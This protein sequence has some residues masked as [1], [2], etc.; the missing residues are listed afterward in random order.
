MVTS[1]PNRSSIAYGS[2][3]PYSSSPASAKFIGTTCPSS[4]YSSKRSP[5][6]ERI[7]LMQVAILRVSPL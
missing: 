5:L 2:V 4:F 1:E 6:G 3:T 7:W